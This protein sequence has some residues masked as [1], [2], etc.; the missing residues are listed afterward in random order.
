MFINVIILTVYCAT[1]SPAIVFWQ[2]YPSGPIPGVVSPVFKATTT[3]NLIAVQCPFR[4]TVRLHCAMDLTYYPF[5][6][7]ECSLQISSCESNPQ[8]MNCY[9]RVNLISDAIAN[10]TM[11]LQWTDVAI[12]MHEETKRLPRFILEDSKQEKC[13]QAYRTGL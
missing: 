9:K 1:W 10:D 5:D 12:E 6:K 2:P 7:Q 3:V 4:L 13:S 8:R 11:V